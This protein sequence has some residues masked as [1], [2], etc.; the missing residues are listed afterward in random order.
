M[1]QTYTEEELQ[2]ILNQ[3]RTATTFEN[4]LDRLGPQMTVREQ[5]VCEVF[6]RMLITPPKPAVGSP[7][8]KPGEDSE[9]GGSYP[10]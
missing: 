4:M 3:Q 9:G 8:E 2:M 10:S 7:T 5:N 6:M 1:P